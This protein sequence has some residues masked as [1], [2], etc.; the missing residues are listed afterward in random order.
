MR[1]LGQHGLDLPRPGSHETER[2]AGGG[3][4][5]RRGVGLDDAMFR[6]SAAQRQAD[7]ALEA[8]RGPGLAPDVLD[9]AGLA[10]QGVRDAAGQAK[11][12]YRQGYDEVAQ[13]PGT[14]ALGA[15]D[16]MGSRV[17]GRAAGHHGQVP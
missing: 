5:E 2:D 15:L 1:A 14:F 7:Q 9:A 12:A 3:A 13:I 11:A 16:R 8:V 4:H 10:S 17:A 6:S